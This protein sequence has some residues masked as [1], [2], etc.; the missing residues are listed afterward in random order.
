M[1]RNLPAVFV[2]SG[3]NNIRAAAY[4]GGKLDIDLGPQHRDDVPGLQGVT[5][6]SNTSSHTAAGAEEP[7]S[8]ASSHTPQVIVT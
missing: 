7:T 8:A 6:S 3:T 2:I 5:T 1:H 4:S